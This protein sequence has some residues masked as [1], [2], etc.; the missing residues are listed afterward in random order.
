MHR[1]SRVVGLVALLVAMFAG[2]LAAQGVTSAALY[3][4]VRSAD[5]GGIAEAVVTVTNTSDGGRWRTTTHADGRY[6]FE[7]LSAGGPYAVEARAIGFRIA[8]LPR[9]VAPPPAGSP[10]RPA[11][12]GSRVI[13]SHRL[14]AGSSPSAAGHLPSR[15]GN[16]PGCRSGLRTP[17]VTYLAF[18]VAS[19]PHR[20]AFA[21]DWIAWPTLRIAVGLPQRVRRLSHRVRRLPHRVPG[22]R[23]ASRARRIPSLT[24]RIGLTPMGLYS[25]TWAMAPRRHA[26]GR[27]D[28]PQR[29]P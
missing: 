17:R 2:D 25:G 4:I 29:L 11:V 7:Y 21:T 20:L 3:G 26:G 13:A 5:S 16:D 10:R 24:H 14:L 12:S 22:L 28:R 9:R 8:R 19:S 6:A 23:I 27:R 15:P 1:F 18:R